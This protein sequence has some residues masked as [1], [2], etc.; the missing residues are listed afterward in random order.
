MDDDTFWVGLDL[1]LTRTSVC[2]MNGQGFPLN[3][4][5]CASEV[6]ALTEALAAVAIERIGGIAVGGGTGTYV[7]RKLRGAGFAVVVFEGREAHKFRALR[8]NK[9]DARDA[10]GLADLV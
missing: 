9:S 4:F 3:A 2:I 7:V 8:G 6:A 10:R 1:G 5:E